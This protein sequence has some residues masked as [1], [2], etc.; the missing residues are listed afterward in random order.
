MIL[1]IHPENPQQRLLDQVISHVQKGA[2]ICYPTDTGYGIG[3]DLFN[4]K[5]VKRLI[6]LKKRPTSK[7]FSGRA[8]YRRKYRIY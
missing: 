3:C 4:Q 7:K 5:A 1:S 8:T 2:V 6:Q